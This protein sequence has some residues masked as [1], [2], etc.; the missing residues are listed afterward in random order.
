MVRAK[1]AAILI[2]RRD[3]PVPIDRKAS[4]TA[5]SSPRDALMS[6]EVTQL[7]MRAKAPDCVLFLARFIRSPLLISCWP[8]DQ[9]DD[10]AMLGPKQAEAQP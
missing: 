4:G 2:E 7:A 6:V 3:A 5:R 9:H 8:H 10:L 1:T